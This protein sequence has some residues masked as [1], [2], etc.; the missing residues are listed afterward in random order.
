MPEED[1][2]FRLLGIL[3]KPIVG[4]GGDG[5]KRQVDGI[6]CYRDLSLMANPDVKPIEN[7]K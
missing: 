3:R 5:V 1:H 6:Y 4:H 2:Q 7:S